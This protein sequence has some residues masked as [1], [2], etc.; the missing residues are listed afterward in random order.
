MTTSLLST[1]LPFHNHHNVYMDTYNLQFTSATIISNCDGSDL[2][3]FRL[4]VI[5]SCNA[6]AI[7]GCFDLKRTNSSCTLP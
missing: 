3:L 6:P 2:V 5:P 1:E 4:L 7:L